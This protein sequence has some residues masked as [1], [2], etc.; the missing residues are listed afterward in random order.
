MNCQEPHL[1]L[2]TTRQLLEELR[3]RA[4]THGILKTKAEQRAW[5][6]AQDI[7]ESAP[8]DFLNYRTVDS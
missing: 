4:N 8:Q 1:G 2:A 6:F 5:N 3:A 7:L